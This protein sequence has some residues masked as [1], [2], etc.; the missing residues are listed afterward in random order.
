MY[1]ERGL[2][3]AA[4]NKALLKPFYDEFNSLFMDRNIEQ[5]DNMFKK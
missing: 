2:D 3:L 5:I 1:D 4:K